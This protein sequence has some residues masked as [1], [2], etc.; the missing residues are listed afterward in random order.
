MSVTTTE[1]IVSLCTCAIMEDMKGTR[2]PREAVQRGRAGFLEEEGRSEL[3]LKGEFG[4]PR[5][6]RE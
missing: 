6:P 3:N 2:K 1:M 5:W 4:S